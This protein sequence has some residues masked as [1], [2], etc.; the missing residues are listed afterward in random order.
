V[1]RFSIVIPTYERRDTVLRTVKALDGQTARDFEVVVVVDGSSDGTAAALR[2]LNVTFPLTVLE[3]RNQ[4]RASAVNAGAERAG[5]E[6]LLFLDDDM[7]ADHALLDE[8]ERSHRAGADVVLGDL[9][10]DPDSPRYLLSWGVGFWA[11]SRRERLTAPG[12]KIELGDLLTGQM[13]ISRADFERLGG[14]DV[15]FTRDGLFGG[16]DI[17]LGY[18]MLKAGLHVVFNP[19]AA[20]YQYYDVDPADYLRR[21]REAGR[22]DRELVLKHPELAHDLEGGP[23]FHTRRSRWTLS[24][25]VAAPAWLSEPL[26]A[27]VSALVR[28]GRQGSLIRR[29]FFAMRTMEYQRG[30]R[31][32]RRSAPAGHAVVLAYHSIAD[33]KG[34]PVLAEYG[35]PS[36]RFAA[37]LDALSTHG[38]TFVDLEALLRDLAGEQPLPRRAVLLTFD[39]AY[40]D[41]LSAALPVLVE[42]QLP[43]VVFAVSG[44]TGGTNEWDHHLGVTALRLLDAEGL[45]TAAR[46]GVEVGSH[47]VTHRVLPTLPQEQLTSE[48]QDSADSLES[49]GLPRPRAFSYPHGEWSPEVAA[50][51]R[52]ARYLAAFT[53]RTGLVGPGSDAY[54]LPRVEVFRSDTPA[55]LRLK[56]ATAAWPA[57]WRRPLLR[58]VRARD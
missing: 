22:S 42:R 12:A 18:R 37:Q 50:A 40:A 55:K 54:A 2:K 16:E 4:G 10:I 15:S 9:P 51:V 33:L 36:R 5:G 3:Q 41:L 57:R 23:D 44:Q 48:V 56:L 31:Q 53:V 25:L 46:Q 14:F 32:V 34:D 19:A 21:T 24:P 45:R 58:L 11:R 29:L 7:R 27:G 26:R 28:T 49:L 17:D 52:D 13:S 43:A 38:W 47:S 8:H 1:T 35:V 30:A 6:L 39:D 20:S